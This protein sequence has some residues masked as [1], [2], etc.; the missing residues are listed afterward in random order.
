MQDKDA[1]YRLPDGGDMSIW[2]D[3]TIYGD[4]SSTNSIQQQA[5]E[6]DSSYDIL[7]VEDDSSLANLEAGILKA[8]GYLVTIASNGE[9]AI[10]FLEH[11]VPDLILLD[12]DLPGTINGWDVLQ[13]LRISSSVPV[14]L[15]SAES[16]V[17]R[18]IRFRGETRSTLDLLPKP[19][20]MQTLLKRIEHML[21]L[22]P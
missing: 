15:T 7:I 16:S 18:Q 17:N 11:S 10:T 8:R 22:A 3:S 13:M 12:L 4:Q 20:L 2:N 1:A 21:T 9:M 5:R 19:F 14:L 6:L